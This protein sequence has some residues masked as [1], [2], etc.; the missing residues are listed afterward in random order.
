MEKKLSS[1]PWAML[2]FVDFEG[3]F[4]QVTPTFAKK[5]G[6]TKLAITKWPKLQDLTHPQDIDTTNSALSRLHNDNTATF[7]IRCKHTNNDYHWLLWQATAEKNGFYAQITDISKYKIKN[8]N[9]K[10]TDKHLLLILDSLDALVYV[11]DIETYEIIYTNKYGQDIFG[12]IV[13]QTCWQAF[14]QQENSCPFCSKHHVSKNNSPHEWECYS[15]LTKKWYRLHE[16]TINW[17]DGRLV[18]LEIAYDIT[19]HK[20]ADESL[21]TSQERY[22]LAVRAGKTGVWDWNLLTNEMYLGPHQKVLLGL[23]DIEIFNALEAWM[24]IVHPDDVKKLQDASRNYLQKK[25]SQFEEEYRI[26]NKDNSVDWMI[27]RGTAVC[28]ERGRAYRMVGTNTN[29]TERKSFDEYLQEQQRLCRGVSD[30]THVLLTISDHDR[31][32]KLA[33]EM[34]GKLFEVNRA[35]IFENENTNEEFIINQRF[36]WI[37]NENYDISYKLQRFSYDKYLPGWYDILKK[38]EP[39]LGLVK[40]FP[41]PIYS[42]LD[43][44]NI[45]SIAIVPIHFEGQ[46]WGFIGL[47]DCQN[48]RQ[49]SAYEIAVLNVIGDSVRGTLAH[50]QFKES[51]RQSEAKSSSIIK[52]SRDSIFVCDREGLIRFVNPAGKKLYKAQSSNDMIGKSLC[53]P[54]RAEI[55]KKTEFKFKDLE[56]QPHFGELQ[57]SRIEWEGERLTL[58]VL[59]DISDRKQAELELQNSK[60]AAETAN[61]SKSLFLAAMSHEIRTPMNGVLGMAKLLH[62]TKL[63]R[64]QLHYVKMV[65]NSGQVLLT[66]INDILD[67]SRI[68]AG[69]GL[70]LNVSEFNPRVMIKEVVSL[71][72]S[73]A[74]SKKLEILCQLP[75]ELPIKILGDSGRLWQILNNLLGNAIKFTNK[76]EVQLRV[77]IFNETPTNIVLHFEVIDTGIGI[78]PEIHENLFKLYSRSNDSKN[79]FQ[80]TGLGLFISRQLVHKMG[81]EIDLNSKYGSGSNFWFKL[82]FEKTGNLSA[83]NSL[84]FQD[85]ATADD[86]IANNL[87]LVA[88][89]L[90]GLKLLIVDDNI[91]SQQILL[92]ET[93]VWKIHADVANSETNAFEM[94]QTAVIQGNAYQLALIDAEL[95]KFENGLN[96]LHKIQAESRLASLKLVMMTTLQNPLS[97][98][99]LDQISSHLN[100]PIFKLDLLMTLLAAI[101]NRVT[102]V[103]KAIVAKKDKEIIYRCFVLL[104]EDNIINQE[105]AKDI[106]LQMH[107]KVELA[108]NG[109]EA[110]A[111]VKQRNF[112]LIF[113]DCN[114]PELDGYMASKQIREYEKQN[115]KKPIPIIA[116]TADVMPSTQEHCLEAGMDDYLTKPIVLDELEKKLNKW[117]SENTEK[118]VEKDVVKSKILE[119][120]WRNLKP[121][122][123][124]WIIE[125][126]LKELPTYLMTLKQAI[127]LQDSETIYSAAHK[128]KGASAILGAKQIVDLCKN[129]EMLGKN[130][131]L[132]NVQKIMTQLE[133]ECK[134]LE[135]ILQEQKT[136]I[137]Q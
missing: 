76:G 84:H 119:D 26:I 11:A 112:D 58:A 94:L 34:L 122:K 32:I 80:G 22:M 89:K 83:K 42:L 113:M 31:A 5:L 97:T 55:K 130:N 36:N 88:N 13:G 40:E 71:F 9:L 132:D 90:N 95:P 30:I 129:L 133:A 50:Q 72:A 44:Q 1:L 47:D 16:H 125:L 137:V 91:S 82:P 120:M 17:I 38:D 121:S 51:L 25:N 18:R 106:L 126:Y 115:N 29:I 10:V 87:S 124:K 4:K 81:G 41:E 66:V 104:A 53:V 67:F 48:T 69:K 128:F 12:A 103:K 116:F 102:N 21:K 60:E 92:N 127:D 123:V 43:S 46:F 15:N 63:T 45:V 2:C 28:D 23:D 136:K 65:E 59:R 24:S 99:I 39:I 56:G 33:L 78:E 96:L 3:N 86:L 57:L 117:L 70:I 54:L 6:H 79:K 77:S 98:E 49:W 110:V 111:A 118:N 73:S 19:E 108:I 52:S 93:K 75:S 37:S 8:S 109:L 114:M 101:E 134:Q 7:E 68:E 20:Q 62:Q 135:V 131:Q 74:Q 14:S 27:V 61:R 105:V 85:D 35:Y 64:Q 107:C 100:K